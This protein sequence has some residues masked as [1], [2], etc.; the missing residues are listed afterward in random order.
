MR[1]IKFRA[2]IPSEI[3]DND[4]IVY[5][6]TYDLAFEVF[7]PINDLL[8]SLEYVMQFTGLVN[9]KGK[10]IYEG[11]IFRSETEKDYGDERIYSVV[12]W[13][14]ERGAFYLIPVDYYQI[15]MDNDNLEDDTIF[16]WLFEDANLYDFS[17]DVGLDLCGNIYEN[18]DLASTSNSN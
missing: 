2:W 10:E 1:K 9:K 12:T 17:I 13:I 7:A 16:E 11:D 6:M 3:D 14:K 15:Y 5:K 4:D 18:P 8:D